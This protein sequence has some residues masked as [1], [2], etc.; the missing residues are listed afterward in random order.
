MCT[1]G[2]FANLGYEQIELVDPEKD[3]KII[4]SLSTRQEDVDVRIERRI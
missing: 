2:T 3:W 4:T 1:S